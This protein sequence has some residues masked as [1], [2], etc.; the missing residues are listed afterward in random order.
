MGAMRDM[1]GWCV[2][3]AIDGNHL[4]AETL[5]LDCHFFTQFTGA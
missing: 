4:Y 3:I 1:H 5:T 2:G